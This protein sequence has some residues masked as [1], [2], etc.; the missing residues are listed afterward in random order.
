MGLDWYYCGSCGEC[1][2]ETQFNHCSVCQEDFHDEDDI[3]CDKCHRGGDGG[4]FCIKCSSDFRKK[5]KFENKM[6]YLYIH[7]KCI[8]EFYKYD[9]ECQECTIQNYG[10][11]CKIQK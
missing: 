11:L 5:V 7:D 6:Y 4:L 2:I 9:H 3:E 10:I 1:K 8:E